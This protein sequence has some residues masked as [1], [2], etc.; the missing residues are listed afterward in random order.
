MKNKGNERARGGSGRARRTNRRRSP[1]GAGEVRTERQRLP[2]TSD[3][4]ENLL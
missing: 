1:A 2:Q 3:L 4:M